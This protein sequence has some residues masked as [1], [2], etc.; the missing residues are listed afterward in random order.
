MIHAKFRTRIA[1]RRGKTRVSRHNRRHQRVVQIH[2]RPQGVERTLGQCAFAAESSGRGRLAGQ[3]GHEVHEQLGQFL[4]MHRPVHC[5]RR[6]AAFRI[7]GTVSAP[8]QYGV[9]RLINR[10]HRRNFPLQPRRDLRQ[11]KVARI[12]QIGPRLQI[13]RIG[14]RSSI[15]HA[16]MRRRDNILS[17]RVVDETLQPLFH[18]LRIS[19][20]LRHVIHQRAGLLPVEGFKVRKEIAR[21]R[22]VRFRLPVCSAANRVVRSLEQPAFAIGHQLDARVR[23]FRVQIAQALCAAVPPKQ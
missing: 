12:R 21:T 7:R 22:D 18:R 10:T 1:G 3:A 2:H 15:Y 20:E 4:I 11:I 23:I 14:G 9:H 19:I 5:Q 16:W 17:L 13:A 8:R 6:C